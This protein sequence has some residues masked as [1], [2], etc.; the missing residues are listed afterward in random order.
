MGWF[1][2]S[3]KAPKWFPEFS[4]TIPAQTGKIVAITG[5]TSGKFA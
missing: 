5:C 4:E 2:S 3:P 1:S